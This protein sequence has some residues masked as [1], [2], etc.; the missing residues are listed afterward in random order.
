MDLSRVVLPVASTTED[1]EST[2]ALNREIRE[3]HEMEQEFK[4]PD[5]VGNW[6]ITEENRHTQV[7]IWFDA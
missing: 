2:E 7:G 3:R 4:L 5:P 6:I 1:T